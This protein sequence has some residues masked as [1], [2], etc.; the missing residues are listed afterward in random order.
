MA[1]AT[2]KPVKNPPTKEKTNMK[3]LQKIAGLLLLLS[4]CL[5]RLMPDC[6]GTYILMALPLGMGMIFSK[7]SI[8]EWGIDDDRY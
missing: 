8:T 3:T 5:F 6:D 1:P 7:K 4:C 2:L